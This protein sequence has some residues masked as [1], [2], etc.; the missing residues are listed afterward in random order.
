MVDQFTNSGDT[1]QT[2]HSVASDLGLHCLPVTLLGLSR[3]Q[4]VRALLMSTYNL[5]F[6]VEIQ[7]NTN[8]WLKK[9][10]LI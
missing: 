3:L 2:P 6:H 1:D 8:I 5:C 4:W 10:G 7:K 9:K